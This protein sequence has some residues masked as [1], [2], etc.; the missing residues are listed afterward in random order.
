MVE[1]QLVA[2]GI[3]DS[4]VLEA[5]R[6]VPR[7]QFV[8]EP[9]RPRSYEDRALA[10]GYDQTISQPYM[11]ASALEVL[12]LSGQENVLEI[13]AGSGYEAALLSHLAR[14]VETVES[15][16]E[17]VRLAR[18]NLAPFALPNVHLHA[19]DGSLGWPSAAPFDAIIVAAAAPKIPPPLLDQL[20]P[21]GKLLIPLGD[22]AQQ[23]LTLI[24]KQGSELRRKTF[25]A[26]AFVPLRGAHGWSDR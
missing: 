21:E 8:P 11:V 19:G 1:E 14:E 5:M 13:G 15:V 22:R 25:G 6:S 18:E 9:Q 20:S 16:P 10:I 3:R 24:T 23:I 12:A 17:L 2:R 7:H 4:R 26:C